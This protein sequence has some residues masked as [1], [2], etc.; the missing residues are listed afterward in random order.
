M[1]RITQIAVVCL[2]A[3]SCMKMTDAQPE[4]NINYPAAYVVNGTSST[5]SVINLN[6]NEATDLIQLTDQ[7]GAMAHGSSGM[8]LQ[9]PHHIYLNPAKNQIAIAAPGMDL[10][11]GHGATAAAPHAGMAKVAVL[12]ATKGQNIKLIDVPIMNHNAVYSPDGKEI[13]TSQM[14]TKGSVLVYDATTYVLKNTITVGKEPAEVTFSANGTLAFVANGADNTVSA[15]DPNTKAVKA[16]IP[17]GANPVGAW[18]GS[19][20]RMYADNED[21]Q[22]V[23]VLDVK[24]LKVVETVALGFMPGYAA[25]NGEMKELWVSDPVAGKVHWW[26]QDSNL[27]FVKGGSFATGA[28]AHAIAFRDMTA[29]VT[30]QETASVSV[31]DV[32]KHEKTK[33]I[34]VGQKP[35]G[36]V[37]KF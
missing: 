18:S 32:M 26:K 24:T 4:L 3:T 12:D 22:T 21:G 30:N 25:F 31:V 33:D 6:T 36:I 34:K 37:L 14:D 9:Y 29:Y 2:L 28:G 16:T 20:N 8:F 17:V 15:I 27:K 5:V 10:S 1:K 7:M 13:W 19:D 11:L 35:N 23:S